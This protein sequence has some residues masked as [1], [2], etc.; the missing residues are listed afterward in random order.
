MPM[1]VPIAMSLSVLTAITV[2]A[3]IGCAW[4]M[5]LNLTAFWLCLA[6]LPVD[7]HITV[8][9]AVLIAITVAKLMDF[10]AL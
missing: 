4:Y 5:F 7:L 2:A 9:M 10:S 3:P 6:S 1:A 8:P